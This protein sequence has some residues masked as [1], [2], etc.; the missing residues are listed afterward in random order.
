MW[1]YW[2]KQNS[3]YHKEHW[4]R[5]Y[6]MYHLFP[7]FW[8]YLW[9]SHDLNENDEQLLLGNTNRHTRG[10]EVP[11]AFLLSNACLT[12]VSSAEVL[13]KAFQIRPVIKPFGRQ[14]HWQQGIAQVFI[15][16]W[17]QLSWAFKQVWNGNRNRG[18][19]RNWT[20]SPRKD[21][22]DMRILRVDY[23]PR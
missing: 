11:R 17:S 20:G 15:K 18:R 16:Q 7:V 22:Y 13:L 21:F 19:L 4:Y 9:E 5:F 2:C 3:R 6:G 14:R 23:S 10:T 1:R 12:F 8:A